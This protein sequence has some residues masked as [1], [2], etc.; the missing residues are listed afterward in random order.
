MYSICKYNYWN[1][2]CAHE[3]CYGQL[4]VCNDGKGLCLRW[5]STRFESLSHPLWQMGFLDFC[6]VNGPQIYVRSFELTFLSWV[7]LTMLY[8]NRGQMHEELLTRT[9]TF[10]NIYTMLSLVLLLVFKS[11]VSTNGFRVGF[12]TWR[13]ANHE[14]NLH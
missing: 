13:N 4:V 9:H 12:W 10:S 14:Q 5:W 8:V 11:L 2:P 1:H 7:Y 3:L 6:I